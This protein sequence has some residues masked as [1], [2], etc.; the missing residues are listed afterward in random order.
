MINFEP[1]QHQIQHIHF[2]GIGGI[3]MSAIAE[4]LLQ[5]GYKISGSDMKSSKITE[6]LKQQGI[7]IFSDIIP[8]TFLLVIWSFIRLQSRR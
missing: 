8:I 7:E 5:F 4:I 2:I 6:K 3:G 1:A